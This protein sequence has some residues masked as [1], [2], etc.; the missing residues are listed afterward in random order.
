MKIKKILV[1]LWNKFFDIKIG[2]TNKLLI[3]KDSIFSRFQKTPSIKSIE[4]TINYIIEN[5]ASVSRYGDGEFKL[6]YG[7]SISFQKSNKELQRRLKEVLLVE[8]KNFT[9]CIPDIFESLQKYADEPRTYWRLHVAKNRKKWYELLNKNNVYGNSFISRCYYQFKDKANSGLYFQLLKNVWNNREIVLIEGAKSR[10]GIGNDL[11][12]NVKS[13]ER[14]LVPEI[15]AF[16]KYNE[17]LVEAKRLH[18]DKLIL[19]AA[20]PTATVLAYDLHK[21]GYQTIDIGHVDIEYEW[22]LRKA[23]TKI[24]IENKFVCEAGFG[25]GVGELNDKEYQS[26][27]K[28]VI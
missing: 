12:D 2:V 11:F 14:I 4:E 19:L 13:I 7:K 17:I 8:E 18:K 16:D 3:F 6:A 20:G 21:S 15:N 25:E 22:Y 1:Y 5:R 23:Q 28:A 24:K 9:V 27:I 26:Q 10:L